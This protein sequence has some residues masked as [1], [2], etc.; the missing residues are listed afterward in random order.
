M[1]QGQKPLHHIPDHQPQLLLTQQIQNNYNPPPHTQDTHNNHWS[2]IFYHVLN[3][4]HDFVFTS[5]PEFAFLM[6]EVPE[7][8]YP[9]SLTALEHL[10]GTILMPPGASSPAIPVPFKRAVGIP[11]SSHSNAFSYKLSGHLWHLCS[12]GLCQRARV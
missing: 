6:G 2:V 3:D 10:L 11:V 5:E 1:L 4:A 8:V 9:S 12:E 7:A